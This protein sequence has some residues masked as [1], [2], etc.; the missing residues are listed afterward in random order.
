[1]LKTNRYDL[2][3]GVENK[4]ADWQKVVSAV[5]Y[6]LTQARAKFK[7]EASYRFI[8]KLHRPSQPQSFAYF[9]CRYW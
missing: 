8:L 6:E 3:L 7:K 1:M 2:P 4:P 9:I 5:D